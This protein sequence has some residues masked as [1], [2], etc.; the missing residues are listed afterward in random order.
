MMKNHCTQ[1]DS[2]EIIE[3][4]HT[5]KST[6]IVSQFAVAKWFEIIGQET[7]ADAI[8]DSNCAYFAPF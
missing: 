4:R 2:L 1:L 7:I 6:I 5:R 3:N 8:G